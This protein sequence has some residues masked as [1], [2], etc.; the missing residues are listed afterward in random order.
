MLDGHRW[1]HGGR[2]GRQVGDV[3]VP[4]PRE[5][6]R[7]G[8]PDGWVYIASRQTLA[9]TYASTCDGLVYVVEPLG[10]VHQDPGSILPPWE[11]ARC[12]SARIVAIAT[13]NP[14]EQN[15][16]AAMVA[17]VSEEL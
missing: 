8:D 12:R 17:R 2:T 3:L 9:A 10:D 5:L 11:S 1:Y 16:R 7:C 13:L 14:T 6:T 4:Q 15:V